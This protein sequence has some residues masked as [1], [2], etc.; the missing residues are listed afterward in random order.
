MK[1]AIAPLLALVIAVGAIWYFGVRDTDKK[2]SLPPIGVSAPNFLEKFN[3]TAAT[4]P[5]DFSLDPPT[6]VHDDAINLDVAS[7]SISD[8]ALIELYRNSNQQMTSVYVVAKPGDA[9]ERNLFLSI[10]TSVLTT[11]LNVPRDGARSVLEKDLKVGDTT[12]KSINEK[13]ERLGLRFR[14]SLKDNAYQLTVT[15]ATQ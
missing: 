4:D 12:L 15:K 7:Y 14:M 9:G 2:P 8:W 13:I 5:L 1:R 6:W 3:A 11:V 10:G